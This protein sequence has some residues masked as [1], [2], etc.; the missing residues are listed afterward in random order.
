MIIS[1]AASSQSL[2]AVTTDGCIWHSDLMSNPAE[3]CWRF[4]DTPP[5]LS[6][7]EKIEQI[8]CSP[9]GKY[10]WVISSASHRMW[11]RCDVS[12]AGRCGLLWSEVGLATSIMFVVFRL[13]TMSEWPSW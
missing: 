7:G 8:R 6:R 5:S 2:W 3:T 4:V 12:E 13:V 1:F 10:V 11:A 9:S